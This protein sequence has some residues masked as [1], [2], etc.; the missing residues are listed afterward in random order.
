MHG[1]GCSAR[2]AAV[3][4]GEPGTWGVGA[5]YALYRGYYAVG[6]T[7]LLPGRPADPAQFS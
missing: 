1:Q 4:A 6:G 3:G 7:L 5:V 2:L